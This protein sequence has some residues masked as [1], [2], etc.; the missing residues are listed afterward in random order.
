MVGGVEIARAHRWLQPDRALGAGGRP[1]PKLCFHG[2]IL[3]VLQ[4]GS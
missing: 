3:Y 1:D 2:E 4:S